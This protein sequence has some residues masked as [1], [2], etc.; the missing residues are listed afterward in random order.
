MTTCNICNTQ[1]EADEMACSCG[2]RLCLEC[3]VTHMPRC[4]DDFD[5]EAVA[6]VR[7]ELQGAGFDET[8][9]DCCVEDMKES[10]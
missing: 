6:A 2:L 10:L 4:S 5:E 3:E 7:D 8:F 9:I 1:I